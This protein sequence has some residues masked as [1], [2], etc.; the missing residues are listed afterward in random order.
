VFPNAQHLPTD[1][2]QELICCGITYF[3]RVNFVDPPHAICL[4]RGSVTTAPVPETTVNK[5]SY[6]G[7]NKS[8][9]YRAPGQGR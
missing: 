1:F 6:L 4:W 9:I 7:G 3:I 8:D 5:Y 2:P